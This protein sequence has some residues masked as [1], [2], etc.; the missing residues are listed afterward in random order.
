MKVKKYWQKTN[1]INTTLMTKVKI[2]EQHNS[3]WIM[4]NYV[5]SLLSVFQSFLLCFALKQMFMIHLIVSMLDFRLKTLDIRI[6]W[7]LTGVNERETHFRNRSCL[8]KWMVAVELCGDK[9]KVG[10]FF[11]SFLFHTAE[12][13]SKRNS[14]NTAENPVNSEQ[15]PNSTEGE[16]CKMEVMEQSQTLTHKYIHT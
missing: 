1:N 7:N 9:Y 12:E 2:Q 10:L 11:F 16:M 5:L 15:L 3:W 14:T 6:L 4:D 8:K 13:D